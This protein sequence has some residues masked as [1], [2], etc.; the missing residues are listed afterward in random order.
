MRLKILAQRRYVL[1]LLD[2]FERDALALL[3][4]YD[5]NLFRH[6]RQKTNL[7]I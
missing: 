4:L 7:L 5:T 6:P 1:P 3:L 2:V